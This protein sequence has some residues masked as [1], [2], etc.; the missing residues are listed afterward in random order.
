M[1]TE[2]TIT[3]TKGTHSHSFIQCIY[4]LYTRYYDSTTKC[5]ITRQTFTDRCKSYETK[6]YTRTIIKTKEC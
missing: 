3:F 2:Y 4:T 5:E 1:L 6:G